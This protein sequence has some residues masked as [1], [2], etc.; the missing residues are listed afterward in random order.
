[1][2]SSARNER[3]LEKKKG[4]GLAMVGQR[5]G[6]SMAGAMAPLV[7][8]KRQIETFTEAAE[9]V[10]EA[11]RQFQGIEQ[12][13][14]KIDEARLVA[15]RTLEEFAGFEY[16]LTKQRFVSLRVHYYLLFGDYD[17]SSS[18]TREE[19][20]LELLSIEDSFRA[21]YD[22]IQALVLLVTRP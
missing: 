7:D 6:L 5:A 2:A 17:T 15:A 22:A 21:E 20:V 8:L 12:V 14:H 4:N 3:R 18:M 1:V 11:A 19:R 16:E 10:Q 9:Q 13:V